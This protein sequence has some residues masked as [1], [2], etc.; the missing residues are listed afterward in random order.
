MTA[1]TDPFPIADKITFMAG[2]LPRTPFR[3][4]TECAAQAGFDS[5]TLWPN[6]WRHAQRKEGLTLADMRAMLEHNGLKLTDVD[7]YRGW[8]PAPAPD[9]KELRL[10]RD[11]VALEEFFEVSTALGGTTVVAAHMTDAPF[12]L[13]R[14]TEGF[15][16]LCDAAAAR[17]LRIALEAIAF[18][19]VRD[20]ATAWK[21]VEGAGRDNGGIAADVAHHMRSTRDHAAL[22]RIDPARIFTVQLCDGPDLAPPD[23]LDEAM[24]HRV[25]PGSGDMDVPGFI[26]TLTGMGVRA[27]VGPE[28]YHES[29]M[30]RPP[31]EVMRELYAA[32]RDVLKGA[33]G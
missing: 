32:T 17:G 10:L 18:S 33:T 13:D 24:Y 20:L 2:C 31:L 23:L 27:S 14:D 1:A 19:N 9:A 12:D 4:L 21:V 16:R 5:I 15:A 6:I 26:R 22:R 7:A 30:T 29:F 8:V 28:V 3:Q 11:N 25:L